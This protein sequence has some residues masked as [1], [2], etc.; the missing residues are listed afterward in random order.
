MENHRRDRRGDR[1]ARPEA[2]GGKSAGLIERL[3]ELA[4]QARRLPPPNH[5]RP[6]CF[7]EARDELGAAIE[8]C[9]LELEKS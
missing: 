2:V 4:R 8:A 6:E 9:A 7:H 5:R 3:R 1:L